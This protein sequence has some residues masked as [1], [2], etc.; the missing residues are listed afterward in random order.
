M[1]AVYGYR[2]IAC[3]RIHIKPSLYLLLAKAQSA[4]NH[5]GVIPFHPRHRETKNTAVIFRLALQN[6][7]WC[8][9][10]DSLDTV[11]HN[12]FSMIGL[13]KHIERLH[14]LN[15]VSGVQQCCA[16]PRQC[17][18]MTRNHDDIRRFVP[19]EIFTHNW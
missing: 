5:L 1:A 3:I 8:D 19:E 2:T 4:L 6:T 7:G 12:R 15:G 16:I 17:G 14:G 13:W 11:M 9:I 10:R 18:W